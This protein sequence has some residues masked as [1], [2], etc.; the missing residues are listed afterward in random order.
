MFINNLIQIVKVV[1]HYPFFPLYCSKDSKM[2]HKVEQEI[3]EIKGFIE[4]QRILQKEHFNLSEAAI[5]LGISKSTLY[6]LTSGRL[7]PHFKPKEKLIYFLKADLE[8]WM[9]GGKVETV[10]ELSQI[11]N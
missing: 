11:P 6:K 9:L 1:I 5:Y 3:S 8:K 7:I 10:E 2:T 4:S